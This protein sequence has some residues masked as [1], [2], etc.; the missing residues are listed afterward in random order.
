MDR[1]GVPPNLLSKVITLIHYELNS[2]WDDL[3]ERIHAQD[4][5]ALR[6]NLFH[7]SCAV[8]GRAFSWVLTSEL[9]W[10]YFLA[11]S[12]ASSISQR[13]CLLPVSQN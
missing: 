12:L 11:W 2:P 6:L 9:C 3:Q 4:N 5:L 10:V 13:V 8:E 1:R 7:C